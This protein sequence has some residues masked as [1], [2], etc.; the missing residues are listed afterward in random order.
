MNRNN[1]LKSS[2]KDTDNWSGWSWDEDDTDNESC[3]GSLYGNRMATSTSE[4]TIASVSFSEQYTDNSL[5][6]FLINNT[7]VSA[8]SEPTIV[9]INFNESPTLASP[10]FF[11]RIPK[12]VKT[13]RR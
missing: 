3:D 7:M 5:S 13:P 10:N 6:G 2:L 8:L 11:I 12:K 9:S 1:I 4:P